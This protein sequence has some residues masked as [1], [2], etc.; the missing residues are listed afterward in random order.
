M[1]IKIKDPKLSTFALVMLI[2]GAVDSI[3]NLPA[4][5]LFGSALI[6]FFVFS[7]I[8]FLIPTAL[9][10]AELASSWTD[11]GGVCYWVKLAFGDKVAFMAIWLQWI[12]NLVWFPTI[13]SF[14]AGVIAYLVNP[15]LVHSKTYLV[16]VILLVFWA[17]TLLNLKGVHV[18][19]RFVAICTIIGMAI[20]MALIIGLA[21]IWILSGH[22]LQIH[23]TAATLLPSF[24]HIDNWISLTAIMT[25]FAGMELSAVHVK[26]IDNPQKSFPRALYISVWLIL[27]TMILGSLAIAVVLPKEHINLVNGIMQAFTR[28]F[29]VYHITWLMPIMT[30]MILLGT[31]GGIISWVIS[32]AKGLL[33]AAQLGFLPT[34]FK[35]VN[36]HGVAANLLMTQAVIVSVICLA[37]LFMPSIGGSYWL[38]TALNIQLYMIMYV[39]LFIAALYLRYKFPNRPRPFSIPAGKIGMWIVCILGLMGCAI[40]LIVGFFPPSGVEVGSLLSYETTFISGIVVMILPTLLFYLYREKTFS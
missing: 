7:A 2:T 12:A 18:S 38:L 11:K 26:E 15:D 10:S 5:A 32:P 40:T 9:V 14:I 35:Q 19:A 20:P 24:S 25:A 30:V 34:F 21:T 36:E 37:F 22:A 6:F 28:F 31:L 27:I 13:L 17:L 33:Q 29:A 16:S 39:M 3:R 23:F 1:S 4:A 8:V